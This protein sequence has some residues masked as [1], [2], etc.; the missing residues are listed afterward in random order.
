MR[1]A[2]GRSN[3][4]LKSY[5]GNAD[6]FAHLQIRWGQRNAGGCWEVQR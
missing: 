3:A 6:G 1:V 4:K 5:M 2:A